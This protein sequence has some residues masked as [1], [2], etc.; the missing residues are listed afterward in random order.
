MNTRVESPQFDEIHAMLQSMINRHH[1]EFRDQIRFDRVVN[2]LR[3]EALYHPMLSGLF[4]SHH[5]GSNSDVEGHYH[6]MNTN[7]IPRGQAA[8]RR[9]NVRY[10]FLHYTVFIN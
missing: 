4:Q 6:R 3:R 7:S 2:N 9:P 5:S 8:L 10:I 1:R